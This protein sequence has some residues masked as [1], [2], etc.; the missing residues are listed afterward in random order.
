MERIRYGEAISLDGNSLDTFHPY[1]SR[2]IHREGGRREPLPLALLELTAHMHILH[3]K[4]SPTYFIRLLPLLPHFEPI[5]LSSLRPPHQTTRLDSGSP[6]EAT[7]LE[8]YGYGGGTS[9]LVLL[10]EYVSIYGQN[11]M[12]QCSESEIFEL[13]ALQREHQSESESVLLPVPLSSL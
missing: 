3:I 7:H 13:L 10:M 2:S 11:G 12:M 8:G 1:P 5:M 6:L 9:Y 4:V